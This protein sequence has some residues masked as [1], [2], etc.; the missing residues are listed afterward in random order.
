[1]GL[2]SHEK[3]SGHSVAEIS[4]ELVVLL[5]LLLLELSVV[6]LPELL[7][8]EVVVVEGSAEFG[9]DATGFP[10]PAWPPDP[11]PGPSIGG[12]GGIGMGMGAKPGPP[13]PLSELVSAD[14]VDG[15][16]LV[17][18]GGAVMVDRVLEIVGNGAA[19]VSKLPPD[20]ATVLVSNAMTVV[21][22]FVERLGFKG[23]VL[24]VTRVER[25]D[26]VLEVNIGARL[27]DET[28]ESDEGDEREIDVFR[29]PGDVDRRLLIDKAD[30]VGREVEFT[31]RLVSEAK[32]P[33]VGGIESETTDSDIVVGQTVL[34]FD[35]M[36]DP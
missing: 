31:A 5:E 35:P 15:E 30:P 21:L 12:N 10:G 14:R 19:V 33:V 11:P 17:V 28:T 23:I 20:V 9:V 6:E 34:V 8:V 2:K 1:M 36:N 32:V 22:M 13:G 18:V 3:Q 25:L 7:V 16:E 27:D 4:Q 29:D 24:E 26:A